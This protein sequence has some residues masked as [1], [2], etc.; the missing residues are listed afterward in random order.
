MWV[1]Y[2]I[3][4]EFNPAIEASKVASKAIADLLHINHAII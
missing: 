2:I 3:K 1:R 4:D